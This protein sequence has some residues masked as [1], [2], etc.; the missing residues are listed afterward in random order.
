MTGI[1]GENSPR[2]EDA[3]YI[4]FSWSDL[5]YIPDI[6]KKTFVP[7]GGATRIFP[8]GVFFG[9]QLI[10]FPAVK[11]KEMLKSFGRCVYCGRSHDAQG[12]AIKLTSEHVISEALGCGTEVPEASCLDCQL[13]TAEF[14]GSVVEEMFDPV[15]KKISLV[16]K[17][18]ILQKKN[19]KLDLGTTNTERVMIPDIHHPT[20]LVLPNLFPAS[21]YSGRPYETHGIFN[22]II[23]NLNFSREN[24]SKYG[25]ELFST[26]VIDTARF[27]QMLAKI[28]HV[29]CVSVYG[30]GSFTPYVAD[31]I[32]T[33][34]PA[35]QVSR[36]HYNFV[37]H[38]WQATDQPSTNLHEVEVGEIVWQGETLV[39]ARVRLF[40]SYDMPSY[41]V[42]VGK[43]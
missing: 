12:K 41:H 35:K 6:G 37:G 4:K 14:E 7:Q 34:L 1:R 23:C 16:G 20:L 36:T 38:L 3:R 27:C 33:A 26:Q 43:L 18:G 21:R 30:P 9:K 11:K 2:V 25:I 32:R 19:F 8:E 17:R 22:F 24:I 15:R 13:V 28:A 42:A 10:A 31:F 39:G 40:A 29:A 5:S